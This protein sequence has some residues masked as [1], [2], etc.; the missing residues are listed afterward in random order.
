MKIKSGIASYIPFPWRK[1]LK[2]SVFADDLLALL[3]KE[4]RIAVVATEAEEKEIDLNGAYARICEALLIACRGN[5]APGSSG[6]PIRLVELTGAGD[7]IRQFV[8]ELD[9]RRNDDGIF[10]ELPL[11]PNDRTM[12]EQIRVQ[13]E[14]GGGQHPVALRLLE[15]AFHSK[16]VENHYNRAHAS[17][18]LEKP[19]DRGLKLLKSAS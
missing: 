9:G 17:N 8:L 12:L 11:A 16:L 14:A 19:T 18:A 2:L 1:H 15:L 4:R 10:I 5:L 7:T 13:I 6:R 3:L